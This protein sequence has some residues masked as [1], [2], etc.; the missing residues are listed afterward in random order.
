[1]AILLRVS[2]SLCSGL[3]PFCLSLKSFLSMCVAANNASASS[4]SM[5]PLLTLIANLSASI[6]ISMY[7]LCFFSLYSL[8]VILAS[9]CTNVVMVSFLLYFAYF[10][11]SCSMH[12][13]IFSS[14]CVCT[15]S[16]KAMGSYTFSCA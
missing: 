12:S 4:S 8:L 5:D 16:S 13:S 6:W 7:V 15:S 10:L 14:L 11:L 3:F 1:M 2:R 9:L